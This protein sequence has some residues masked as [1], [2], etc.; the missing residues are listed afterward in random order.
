MRDIAALP[1]V[2]RV[3][4][5]VT[6]PLVLQEADAAGAV[7]VEAHPWPATALTGFELH[8]GQEPAAADEVVVTVGSGRAVGDT[9]VLAHGGVPSEYRVVGEVAAPVAP[10][11]GA[12]VFLSERRI[13]Q[14][15]PHGGAP[16]ALGVF[17]SGADPEQT[18]SAIHEADPAWSPARVTPAATWS[19]STRVRRGPRSW[20]SAA[21][22]SA[23]AS[24]WRCSSWQARCRCR[25]SRAV[26]TMPLLRAVGASP[27]QV[28]ALVARE[29]LWVSAVALLLGIV[30]GYLLSTVLQSAFVA[31]V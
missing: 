15:D 8:E 7:V 3:V 11:R 25:C 17:V 20:P 24:S 29:V 21:R 31:G 18:A 16:Q 12:H 5:D 4:A 23:R 22:S 6:V 2:D 1:G 26:V 14:L 27:S 28:H 13:D 19:S 10:E 30:P 9:V